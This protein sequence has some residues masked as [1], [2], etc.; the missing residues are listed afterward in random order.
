MEPTSQWR[1]VPCTSGR[2]L[3]FPG[4]SL[5]ER[6]FCV[7]VEGLIWIPNADDDA[8]IP[9]VAATIAMLSQST[10]LAG[11]VRVRHKRRSQW[12]VHLTPPLDCGREIATLYDSASAAASQGKGT[13]YIGKR[14]SFVQFRDTGAHLGFDVPGFKPLQSSDDILLVGRDACERLPNKGFEEM[15]LRDLAMEVAPVREKGG[16]GSV[17]ELFVLLPPALHGLVSGYILDHSLRHQV[18]WLQ[19]EDERLLLM[20][21][22]AGRSEREDPPIPRFILDHLSRFPRVTLFRADQHGE[23]GPSILVQLRHR[24]CFDLSRVSAILAHDE[25]IILPGR[26]QRA[27]RVEPQPRFFDNVLMES[28]LPPAR[29]L[30]A[31]DDDADRKL[32][33]QVALRHDHRT[34]HSVQALLLTEQE[35]GRLQHLLCRLPGDRFEKYQF[36]HCAERSVIMSTDHPVEGIPLGV[37]LRRWK[38]SALFIPVEMGLVPDLP[39]HRL[40]QVLEMLPEHFAF[41]TEELRLDIP[42]KAFTSLS[43]VLFD[44]PGRLRVRFD[45]AAALQLPPL[46]W[47]APR[48]QAGLSTDVMEE[49]AASPPATGGDPGGGPLL[50]ADDGV[51]G[52]KDIPAPMSV[53]GTPCEDGRPMAANGPD[54]GQASGSQ[55]RERGPERPATAPRTESPLDATWGAPEELD[56]AVTTFIRQQARAFEVD[57]DLLKAA[58]CHEMADDTLNAA[59]CYREAAERMKES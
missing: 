23:G 3:E 21:V 10:E 6:G 27:L 2:K 57:G 30:T 11:V 51:P 46:Q 34:R 50:D 29:L 39:W 17:G 28:R 22:M 32:R 48:V 13:L 55:P 9:P 38:D 4:I 56:A 53:E 47:T 40:T 7:G 35:L 31:C 59:R 52:E 25:M 16:F 20:R 42:V 33:V 54:V 58:V 18:A 26:A 44:D 12:M 14:R 49:A 36:F 5:H 45:K 19:A 37:R 41:L 8:D 24:H 43:E 15:S 1:A